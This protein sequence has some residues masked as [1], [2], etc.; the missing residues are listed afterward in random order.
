MPLTE[1]DFECPKCGATM[2]VVESGYERRWRIT[3]VSA[4][5]IVSVYEDSQ[6]DE[7]AGDDHLRCP[8]DLTTKSLPFNVEINYT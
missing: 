1:A 3:D 8:T 2:V 5:G 4:E 6:Y 7:G